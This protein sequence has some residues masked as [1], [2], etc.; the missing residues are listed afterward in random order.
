MSRTWSRSSP[1]PKLNNTTTASPIP[2]KP[3]SRDNGN[4]NNSNN[5]KC[6]QKMAKQGNHFSMITLFSTPPR[7]SSSFRRATYRILPRNVEEEKEVEEKEEEEEEECGCQCR[8]CLEENNKAGGGNNG[9]DSLPPDDSTL[10]LHQEIEDLK[11][12]LGEKEH[13]IVTMESQILVHANQYPHGEM[14]ALRESLHS[15]ADRYERLLEN[16]RKLQ[17]VNQGLEDKL[18]RIADKFEAE[19]ISLTASVAELTSKLASAETQVVSLQAEAEQYK[20]DC[21][22][23][24]RSLQCR[25][26]SQ[27]VSQRIESFPTDVQE[28]V[29]AYLNY[30]KPA[31]ANGKTSSNGAGKLIRVP[32]PTFPPTA[33]LYS[34]NKSDDDEQELWRS[35][36]QQ[37]NGSSADSSSSSSFIS[38][39]IV[40]KILEEREKERAMLNGG[41]W[42]RSAPGHVHA[43]GRDGGDGAEELGVGGRVLH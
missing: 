25:P 15:S 1:Q 31:E 24:I 10:H 40:A 27:F 43:D 33:V 11:G 37:G 38:A 32:V 23:A 18:L 3:I 34:L 7:R 20:A 12:R 5:N 13:Q 4:N 29:Q 22:L 9:I 35:E 14:A 41:W 6:Q 42:W 21:S 30:R 36:G 39:A 2:A 26:A 19:K 16:Y 28:R 17:K 8:S